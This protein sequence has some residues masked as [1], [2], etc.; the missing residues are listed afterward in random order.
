MN[1]FKDKVATEK[2]L[3]IQMHHPD[4][5]S[6]SMSRT[7][8]KAGAHNVNLCKFKEISCKLKRTTMEV[9]KDYPRWDVH[10]NSEFLWYSMGFQKAAY[11]ISM[12]SQWDFKGFP[13]DS[14]WDFYRNPLGIPWY[15]YQVLMIFLWNYIR[16]Q[17]DSYGNYQG[18]LWSF[19]G[20]SMGFLWD[21]YCI[22]MK[23]LW[24][25]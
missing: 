16:C 13:Y 7:L 8:Q 12:E 20:I 1:K 15:L 11:G 22:F 3:D 5:T 19:H 9:P 2:Q 18:F 4:L 21:F 10:H 25:P 14:L 24:N 23:F 17:K 6:Y